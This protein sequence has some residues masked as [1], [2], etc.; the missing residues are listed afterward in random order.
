MNS[1]AFDIEVEMD[2]PARA[3]Y[4]NA[5]VGSVPLQKEI[6]AIDEKIVALVQTMNVAKLK[7]DFMRAFQQDPVKFIA[8][9]TAGQSRDLE[10]ILGDTRMNSEEVISTKFFEKEDFNEALYSFLRANEVK[11]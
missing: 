9:W 10:V 11:N 8:E 2:D 4:Q 7:R 1:N 5:T 3:V 6:A